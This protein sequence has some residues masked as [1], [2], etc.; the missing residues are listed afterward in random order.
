MARPMR[1]GPG[2]ASGVVRSPSHTR[3]N[4]AYW[5]READE[6]QRE[7]ARQ[8]NRFGRPSWGIWSLPEA[9]VRV[10]GEV[11]D[12][13]V[14]E[15]GCGGAQWS[16]S[17]ALRGARA[18]ALD[19]STEQL[20]HARRLMQRAG[21]GVRLVNADAERMPFADRSFDVVFS[22]HGATTFADPRR[23]VPE[24]ARVLRPG[25]VFAFNI[26]SPLLWLCW[27]DDE[28]E[29]GPELVRDYFGLG[30]ETW[31]AVEFQL[32]YGDWIRLF[33]SSG[34]EV[35]DLIELRPP[36]RATTTFPDFVPLAWARRW[37][38]ENIWKLRKAT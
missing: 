38:A 21:V 9:K 23:T 36:P 16:I 34:F 15:L 5:R 6:Y 13:D 3:R 11:A 20:D 27:N 19:L 30:R 14:L 8:L 17:L 37:P 32:S 18:V 10:L 7:H 29:P 2:R 33:R 26:A 1:S 12:H 25:G 4:L 22:D 35:L 24:V 31:E 28:A